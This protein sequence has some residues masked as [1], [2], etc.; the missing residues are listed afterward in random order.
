[1]IFL[2]FIPIK[3]TECGMGP[4][5]N[6]CR[7]IFTDNSA[8]THEI[9]SFIYPF[10]PESSPTQLCEQPLILYGFHQSHL[11]S[12]VWEN[13][14]SCIKEMG[15]LVRPEEPL[16]QRELDVNTAN[17]RGVRCLPSDTKSSLNVAQRQ[18][19]ISLFGRLTFPQHHQTSLWTSLLVMDFLH[20]AAT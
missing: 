4:Q 15:Q 10:H 17:L 5:I 3:K 6:I 7:G 16:Q 8:I 18:T 12:A 9:P 13:M 11:L 1:M 19:G 20:F 14:A 2:S